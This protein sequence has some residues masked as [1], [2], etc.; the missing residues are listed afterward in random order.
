LGKCD[1]FCH[2]ANGFG[3]YITYLPTCLPEFLPK[4][5]IPVPSTWPSSEN[6]K[7]FFPPRDPQTEDEDIIKE[8]FTEVP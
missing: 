3:L 8:T 5:E 7:S 2:H 1:Y 4:Q 6:Q